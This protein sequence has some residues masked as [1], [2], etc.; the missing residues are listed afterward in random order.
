MSDLLQYDA[1]DIN[2]TSIYRIVPSDLFPLNEKSINYEWAKSTFDKCHLFCDTVNG[3][4]WHTEDDLLKWIN[5]AK[6]LMKEIKWCG[7]KAGRERILQ[8]AVHKYNLSLPNTGTPDG[9]NKLIPININDVVEIVSDPTWYREKT[10]EKQA[11]IHE[12]V[13]GITRKVHNFW[14]I[15]AEKKWMTKYSIQYQSVSYRR[16]TETRGFVYK[17]MNCI[18]SNTTIKMFKRA[19]LAKLGEYISVRDNAKLFKIAQ[20]NN[21]ESN[22]EIILKQF[23][24]GKGYIIKNKNFQYN[25]TSANNQ[26]STS[27]VQRWIKNCVQSNKSI[28]KILE[29]VQMM[30]YTEYNKIYCKYNSCQNNNFLIDKPRYQTETTEDQQCIGGNKGMSYTFLLQLLSLILTTNTI[31]Y[32]SYKHT[33]FTLSQRN[34]IE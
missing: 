2:T 14:L 32:L 28:D 22:N 6:S 9:E 5:L 8:L 31:H 3:T 7:V 34:S 25:N 16:I 19:M 30:Y 33:S 27:H 29:E 11:I 1:L 26:T 23:P 17:L 18:F 4:A 21:T 10:T 12:L 13:Y 20:C 24:T 15:Q